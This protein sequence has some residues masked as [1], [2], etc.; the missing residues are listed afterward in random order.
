MVMCNSKYEKIMKKIFLSIMAVSALF[1]CQKEIPVETPQTEAVTFKAYVDGADTKTVLDG[2]ALKTK[3]SGEEWIQIVG[4]KAYWFG[5]ENVTVPSLTTTFT[6]N[7]GNGEY[8]ETGAVMAVYPAGSTPY[9]ADLETKTVGVLNIP[10]KQYPKAGTFDPNAAVAVAYTE[11]STLS[12][13]NAVAL[14]KFTMGAEN[15]TAACIYANDGGDISGTFSAAMTTGIPVLTG[16]AE[17][18]GNKVSQWVDFYPGEGT[19]FVKGSVYYVAIAPTTFPNGFTVSLNGKDVKKYESSAT[20]NRNVIY[21]MGTIGTD[22]DSGD[23]IAPWSVVGTFNGWDKTADPMTLE[24][25]LYVYR[26]ISDLNF[27]AQD[28]AE[29]KSSSTGFQFIQ[30]GTAW[31]GGYGDTE[32]P[33]KLSVNSWSWYWNDGGKNIYVEG[34]SATDKFDV[35]LNP[36]TDKFVIVPAGAAMPEDDPAV[37]SDDVWGVIGDCVGSAW[38]ND[39]EMEKSGDMFVAR[40]VEFAEEGEFKI[41]A[42]KTWENNDAKN[43]GVS[44]AGKVKAGYYYAVIAGGGSGNMTV[45]AG[46]YD[47]WFDLAGMKVYVMAPDADPSTA[48]EGEVEIPEVE[49]EIPDQNTTVPFIFILDNDNHKQWWG[50]VAYLYVWDASGNNIKGDWPGTAMAYDASTFTFTG[51]IPKEYVGKELNFIVHNGNGWQT[52]DSKMTVK[53]E[54]KYGANSLQWK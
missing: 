29:D 24:N 23:P 18:E 10:S 45:E 17:G 35:Y 20:F 7:G 26:G 12:F 4:S 16:V 3:W 19:A 49:V 50:E 15:I 21:D 37:E 14:L 6:Y 48:A 39:I 30:D 32:T 54:N 38:A 13:K 53:N 31:R 52:Q 9:A 1:A 44:K 5:S 25:G 2:D 36:E 28:D 33:G 42:N 8:T 43:I 27:T 41:R 47:I 34:A 11:N 22:A 40:D 51:G 46:T